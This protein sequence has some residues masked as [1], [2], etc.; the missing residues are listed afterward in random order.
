MSESLSYHKITNK[1]SLS[2]IT[3]TLEADP[4]FATLTSWATVVVYM[5][6]QMPWLRSRKRIKTKSYTL[7]IHHAFFV[8]SYSSI[9]EL[10]LTTTFGIIEIKIL[11][12]FL[13][14]AELE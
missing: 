7:P 12:S 5:L 8:R 9:Q 2:D 6:R 14:D 10:K 13:R 4:I 3:V 11:P 1:S